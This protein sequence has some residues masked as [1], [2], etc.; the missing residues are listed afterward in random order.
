M[1]LTCFISSFLIKDITRHTLCIS[2]WL[3]HV[4]PCIFCYAVALHPYFFDQIIS[5]FERNKL[6]C[7]TKKRSP[8][9]RKSLDFRC[10]NQTNFLS[11]L[12]DVTLYI[13]DPSVSCLIEYSSFNSFFQ[14]VLQRC[15]L[16]LQIHDLELLMALI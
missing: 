16:H 4:I 12:I 14:E 1:H 2:F 7:K 3:F 13:W 10:F 8:I 6:T 9:K 15:L 11:D 5:F